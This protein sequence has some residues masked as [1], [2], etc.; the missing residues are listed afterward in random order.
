MLH[1]FEQVV[2][3]VRPDQLELPTPCDD[4]NVGDVLS[5]VAVWVQVFDGAVNDRELDFDPMTASVDAGW[6]DV[7]NRAGASIVAGLRERGIDREMVM[8]ANP[9]PGEFILNMLLMEYVGHGWDLAW[10]LGIAPPH[11]DA[12]AEIALAAAQAIIQP[13][14]RGTGMF[15]EIVE[16]SADASAHD[17]FAGFLGRSLD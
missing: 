8:T 2:R 4:F 6:G 15:D 10:A 1:A 14:Y 13:Q 12:E 11:T 7:L 17:R 9:M 16:A 3:S 5:H